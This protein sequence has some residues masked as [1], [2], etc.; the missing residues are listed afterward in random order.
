LI[1]TEAPST[2]TEA[3]LTG[4]EDSDG[5]ALLTGTEDSVVA[6]VFTAS[7]ASANMQTCDTSQ[8][9]RIQND[10][11]NSNFYVIN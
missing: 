9:F 7:T 6:S 8:K 10:H 5:G 2:G 3:A 11:S 4:T 1:G